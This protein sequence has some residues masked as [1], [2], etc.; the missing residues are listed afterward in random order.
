MLVGS[1]Y[2]RVDHRV[3]IVG[4]VRQGLEKTLP[5]AARGPAGETLVGVAPAA[6]TFWQIAP[7]RP[8]AEL[9]DHGFDENTIAQFAVAA[10]RAG[11]A[12]QQMLDPGELVVSQRMAFHRGLLHEGSP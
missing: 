11:T 3:L 9:P 2:R 8:H 6:K 10:D 4:I 7:R 1:H 12:R 5:N